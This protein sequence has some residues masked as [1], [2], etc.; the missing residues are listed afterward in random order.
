[1]EREIL[2]LNKGVKIVKEKLIKVGIE[3]LRWGVLGLASFVVTYLLENI[4]GLE[5]DKNFEFILLA[6]LRFVDN[7]LHK[8]VAEKGITRF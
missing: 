7:A 3:A 1:M 5:L 4:G 6:G 8:T 2:E